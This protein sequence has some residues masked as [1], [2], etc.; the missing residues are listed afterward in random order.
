MEYKLDNKPEWVG[1]YKLNTGDLLRCDEYLPSS[2]WEKE[3]EG[4]CPIPDGA[5]DYGIYDGETGEEIDGGVYGYMFGE[6]LTSLEDYI[7]FD[8]YLVECRTQVP[9]W[10]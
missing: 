10:Y 6:D 4:N 7:A 1:W 3:W 2:S 9:D 5:I 8:G